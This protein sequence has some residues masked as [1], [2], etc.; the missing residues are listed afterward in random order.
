MIFD[1]VK[2]VTILEEYWPKGALGSIILT[3]R[4][5][6]VARTCAPCCLEVPVF[7][8]MESE[9]LLLSWNNNIDQNDPVEKNAVT[10]IAERIGDLPLAL[11]LVAGYASSIA[12]SY[13]DFLQN[14]PVI[15]R[16][17][18][19]RGPGNQPRISQAYQ[20]SVDSTWTHG[21]QTTDLNARLLMETLA[22]LDKDRLS[23]EFFKT[24][25]AERKYVDA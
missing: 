25:P 1:D 22:F 5:P 6:E 14:Y 20:N 15:D 21:L 12:S 13:N 24:V 7:S 11:S 8:R 9:E 4:D 3:T 19:F 16:D 23:L 18:L 10:K 2:D 17:F